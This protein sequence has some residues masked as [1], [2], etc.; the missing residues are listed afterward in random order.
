M[1]KLH[2]DFQGWPMNALTFKE[3]LNDLGFKPNENGDIVI[4][5]DSPLLEAY[6][7]VLTD[8]GMGYGIREGYIT[9]GDIEVYDYKIGDEPA[10]VF[11]IF[12]E[13]DTPDIEDNEDD[14]HIKMAEFY[15][16]GTFL[17]GIP[18][19][20]ES[21]KYNPED[22]RVFI[23]DGH[24]TADGYGMMIGYEDGKLVRSTGYG[25]FQWGG[26][27]RPATKQEIIQFIKKLYRSSKPINNR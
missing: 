26:K 18:E 10:K 19:D 11:N 1:I 12:I 9:E 16:T 7:S 3:L 23:F 4:P 14:I 15:D 27:V 5:S 21:A 8:D 17:Y 2:Y 6:P 24:V 22:E 20:E 13:P 25:N